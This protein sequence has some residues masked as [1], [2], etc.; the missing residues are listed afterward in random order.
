MN[1]KMKQGI[2]DFVREVNPTVN[3]KFQGW[4]LQCGIFEDTIY[5]GKTYNKKTDEYYADYVNSINP[6]CRNINLFLLSL[7]QEIGHIET[8]DDERGEEKDVMFS[9]LQ[10]E[11]N[12]KEELTDEEEEKYCQLYYRIPLEAN[13][14][15]W[16]IDF[17]LSHRDLME[18]YNWLH[19]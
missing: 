19:N 6:D 13:A 4:D 9:L 12:S 8:Y 7:L 14:T 1:K 2:R 16:G 11:Y 5:V 17:A 3:V 10:L 18:K 15:Q